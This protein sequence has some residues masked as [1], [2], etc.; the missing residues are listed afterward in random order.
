LESIGLIAGNGTFPLLFAREAKSRGYRVCAVGHEGE[1]RSDLASEVDALSWVRVGQLSRTIRAFKGWG[2]EQAVMAGGIDKAGS[3]WRLRPDWRA[4]R[5]LNRVRSRGDDAILRGI[6]GEFEREGIAIVPSTTF[7]EHILVSPGVLAGPPPSAAAREDIRL[8]AR[9]LAAL[10]TLDVGQGV[11][12]EDGVVLAVEAIE[13]TDAAIRRA[14]SVGRGRAVVVK[15]SKR[16]QDMRF[17]VPAIGPT[18]V[19]TM[20]ESGARVL[21]VE[22][23]GSI[24][25]EGEKLAV[26]SA[27]RGISVVGFIG[28]GEVPDE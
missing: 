15:A 9:V 17:D 14:G 27:A 2:V 19:E 24:V 12:V 1:T 5:L 4:L 13:G 7:L 11:V 25:L 23:G 3:L 26:L 16:G 20:A 6:A 22:A 8:G 21:A 28:E 10:G 18:T